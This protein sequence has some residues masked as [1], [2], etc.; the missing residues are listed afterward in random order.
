MVTTVAELAESLGDVT[1]IAQIAGASIDELDAGMI[2]LTKNGIKTDAAAVQLKGMFTSIISPSVEAAKMAKSLG[3]E[4]SASALKSKGFAKFMAD[5]KQKTGGSSEKLSGLFGNVRA[6]TGALVLSGVGAK[7][8]N[9]GLLALKNSSGAT[10]DAFKIMENTIGSKWEKLKNRFKNT[11]TS[12]VDT[13][14]GA[15]GKLADS[16][17]NWI[18]NNESN[19]QKWANNI[20]VAIAKGIEEFKKII[21]FLIEHREAIG[22]FAIA[23]MSFYIAIKAVLAFSAVLKALRIIAL[24]TDGALK[25]T[26]I[27]WIVIAIAAVIFAGIMLYKNWDKIKAGATSLWNVTKKV[28]SGMWES[29]TSICTSIWTTTVNI[30]NSIW[31]AITGV[32]TSIWS[33]ITGI[34]T[35]IGATVTNI[36]TSIW[37]T[38]SN[39]FTS[40]WNV[41]SNIFK[42]IW[43]VIVAILTPISRMY[44]AIFKGIL[45][46]TIIVF[47][48]IGGVIKSVWSSISINI[49]TVLTAIW[50]V[51]TSS[52][53]SIMITIT[54]ILAAIWSVVTSVWNGIITTITTVVTTIL[55]VISSVF[56]TVYG[57]VSSIFNSIW[58]VVTSIWVGISTTISGVVTG[59][60][61]TVTNG[62]NSAKDS[63]VGIFTS[64]KDTVLS[65]FGAIWDGIKGIINGGIGL[66]NGFIGGVNKVIS[67][68]NK[69]PGVNIGVV[70]DIPQFAKGTSYAPGGLSLVGERGPEFVNLG[71]GD[72]VTTADKT[73]K[74]LKDGKT[75]IINNYFSG[76]VGT[77]EFFDE[78]GNHI[79]NKIMLTLTNM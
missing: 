62:F 70:G 6:L 76:N 42:A 56:S 54:T 49:T 32:F 74:I 4:F 17:G 3:L 27:G 26:T 57:V 43:N 50:N 2:A 69:V 71:K 24:A 47:Y 15:L 38:T 39:I 23:F 65:I 22:N 79:S 25:M 60:W 9:N 53:N 35:S 72:T 21:S 5:V 16:V 29:I 34:C 11:C 8:F 18:T 1:P 28:F 20:G 48:T 51:I 75:I 58:S 14:S 63:I 64:I 66:M 13:Q 52:W 73:S 67:K 33:T 59:I 55:T 19:M 12:I 46:V 10:E 36:F 31:S 40:I 61:T 68:A 41:I 45:A 44:E 7:D 77:E 78:C 37:T 30:F